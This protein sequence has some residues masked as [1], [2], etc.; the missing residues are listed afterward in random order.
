[1]VSEQRYLWH[2]LGVGGKRRHG[3]GGVEDEIDLKVVV[4]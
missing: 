4:T 2:G 1:M 3:S